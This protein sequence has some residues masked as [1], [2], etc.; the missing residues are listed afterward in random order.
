MV[1]TA[2]Q[3]TTFFEHANQMGI[4]HATVLQLQSKGITLASDLADFNMASL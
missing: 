2:A 4:P 3:M 1:L